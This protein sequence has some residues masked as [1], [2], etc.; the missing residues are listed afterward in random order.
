MP[1]DIYILSWY[2]CMLFTFY[3]VLVRNYEIKMF[4]H[5]FKKGLVACKP[6]TNP[7][8]THCKLDS[9]E[10]NF[11]KM[12]LKYCLENTSV[13]YLGS[14]ITSWLSH[15]SHRTSA[16]GCAWHLWHIFSCTKMFDGK[17]LVF[18]AVKYDAHYIMYITV[19]SHERH[20]VSKRM[21][22]RLFVQHRSHTNH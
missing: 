5:W 4:N 11:K 19:T 20:G 12:Q 15:S 9:Y 21:V 6:L 17:D 3:Y 18:I 16:L 22:T 1:L 13:C 8:M 7:M 10:Q 14:I 2:F